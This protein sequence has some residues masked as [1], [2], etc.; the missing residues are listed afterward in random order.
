MTDIVKKEILENLST[1]R[2]YVLT[3]LIFSMMLIS[4]IVSYGD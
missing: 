2:F 1:Y 4:I 3:G